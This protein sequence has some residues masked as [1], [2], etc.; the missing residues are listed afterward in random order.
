MKIIVEGVGEKRLDGRMFV[1]RG[2]QGSVY[3][4]QG[5][6]YKIYDSGLP[7]P[8]AKI[9][10]L[11]VLDDPRI[12]KPERL[13]Y[14]ENKTVCGYT[15]N[16]VKAPWTP[17]HLFP[18][19]FLA[20]NKISHVMIADW[21]LQIMHVVGHAHS[22]SILG[23]DLNELNFLLDPKAG[24]FAIDVDSWQTKSF[25]ATAIMDSI[26]DRH[27]KEFSTGTDWFSW[28][29]L[30]FQML[31]GM[32]PYKGNH[33][34]YKGSVVERMDDR[35]RDNVSVFHDQARPLA[36][37]TPLSIIPKGLCE[38]YRGVFESGV[39]EKPPAKFDQITAPVAVKTKTIVASGDIHLSE[40]MHTPLDIV[41]VFS[42]GDKMAVLLSDGSVLIDGQK[43]TMS[44]PLLQASFSPEAGW[45]A[46]TSDETLQLRKVGDSTYRQLASFERVFVSDTGGLCGILS[47]K[48]M[49]IGRIG[50]RH[51][52]NVLD[53]PSSVFQDDGFV[54]QNLL[55][56]WHLVFQI[57]PYQC[58]VKSIPEL[59]GVRLIKG[60]MSRRM[61]VLS[62]QSGGQMNRFE[63]QF[64]SNANYSLKEFH[65][66]SGPDFTFTVNEAGVAVLIDSDDEV[67]VFKT[68]LGSV[69]RQVTAGAA[70]D[71]SF[72]LWSCGEKILASRGS[73]LYRISNGKKP[74]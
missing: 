57:S 9:R 15:M 43:I 74:A 56:R 20:D 66:V 70:I 16:A 50:D 44:S 31:I 36:A 49:S 21:C 25:K 69:H 19:D 55:G 30:T 24:V 60:K 41:R 39:R 17:C 45:L 61:L 72:R 47:G 38:W 52:A 5:V 62:G 13:I 7:I 2:G 67:S 1:A 6:A 14:S 63:F 29:V 28:A 51:V 40:L 23:V 54:M 73:I 4:S 42:H 12:I 65:G 26:R 10:E 34:Q 68:G 35:M 59:D 8:E 3:V 46:V 48:L 64:D 27:A 18:R 11:S 71:G 58:I 37:A 32:H 22:H 33:P 53:V